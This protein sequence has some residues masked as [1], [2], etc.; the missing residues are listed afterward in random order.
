[1]QQSLIMVR[2]ADLDEAPGEVGGERTQCRL[3]PLSDEQPK[4]IGREIFLQP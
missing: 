4:E 2:N 1:M 3:F